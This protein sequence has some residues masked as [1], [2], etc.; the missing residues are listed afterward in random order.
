MTDVKNAVNRGLC[1]GL[2]DNKDFKQYMLDIFET[3]QVDGKLF[4]GERLIYD[5]GTAKRL[6]ELSFIRLM[7]KLPDERPF[8]FDTNNSF[9]VETKVI[10]VDD[11]LRLVNR[12]Y[13]VGLKHN[14]DLDKMKGRS[15]K[16]LELLDEVKKMVED[17]R[18]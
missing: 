6:K 16:V 14:L 13:A 4:D 17:L 10:P 15:E 7:E 9:D 2:L 5:T 3:N 18:K 8:W 1:F 12:A 11:V